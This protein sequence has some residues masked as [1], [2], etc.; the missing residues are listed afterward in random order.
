M[1]RTELVILKNLIY[2]ITFTMRVF[3]YIKRKYFDEYPEAQL[4]RLIHDHIKKYNMP[5]SEE[6]LSISLSED[7]K[8]DDDTFKEITTILD[9]ISKDQTEVQEDWLME[10][11]EKW[12]KE[13][14]VYCAVNES[15]QILDEPKKNNGEIPTL[16]SDALGIT[17]DPNVGHDYVESYA[18]R[19]DLLHTKQNKMPFNLEWFNKVTQGG[20]ES[21]T[22]NII[23][24]GTNVGKSLFMCSDAAHKVTI[25]KNVLYISCEMAE[26]KIGQRIDANILDI[27]MAQM[28]ALDRDAFIKKFETKKKDFGRMFIKEYPPSSAN[29]GHFKHLLQELKLKKKFEPDVVYIDYINI[30]DSQRAK[31]AQGMYTFVK[32]IAEELRALAVEFNVPV[33]SA[34]QMNRDG[35]D[36]SDPGLTNTSESFGLPATADFMF[37]MMQNEELA[38]MR[39]FQV[40]QLKSRYGDVGLNQRFYIGVDKQFM[41][42]FDVKQQNTTT[43]Q[44]ANNTT[45]PVKSKKKHIIIPKQLKFN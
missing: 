26:E 10:T 5:P 28:G 1:Q 20:V 31:L 21:K 22:L 12:C 16:L 37:S 34:T 14:A 45:Q 18:E 8:L 33:W 17:F 24:A 25:G 30:C 13:R 9:A 11:A 43:T 3:P 15:I 6:A 7:S 32:A 35:Y 38:N 23:L 36:S 44:P 40:K 4:F 2:N 29:A 27:A 19:F 39:Q 42:L 41:K